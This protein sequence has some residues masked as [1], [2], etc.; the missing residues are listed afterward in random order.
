MRLLLTSS[1]LTNKSITKALIDLVGK[2]PKKT[3]FVFIPTAA[4]VEIGDKGWLIDD[5]MNVKKQGFNS[6]DI[7]DIS[8]VRK[9][10]WLP[11]LKDANVLLFGGGNTFHLMYWLN[12]SGLSKLL[13]GL[14]KSRVY[15]GISAGSMVASR[16]LSLSQS[17]RLYYPDGVG[18]YKSGQGLGFVDFYI[19]LHLNSPH[20][21]EVRE[22]YLKETA[23]N[24]RE[25]IYALDDE[26][27]VIVNGSKIKVVSEGK[28]LVL[29]Q[30]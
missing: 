18:K 7:V 14:L 12:K 26:S 4:N 16:D 23:K 5:L 15:V 24:F 17:E 22:D 9:N 20:F 13:P 11:R 30:K 2:T 6:V 3:N 25:T 29:N 21:P 19:R 28:Y 27:A 10:I 8:A 1:G